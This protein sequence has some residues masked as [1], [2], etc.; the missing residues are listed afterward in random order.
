MASSLFVFLAS[1]AIHTSPT[2]DTLTGQ[3]SALETQFVTLGSIDLIS[4]H[5]GSEV[6]SYLSQ[7]RDYEVAKLRDISGKIREAALAELGSNPATEAEMQLFKVDEA[8]LSLLHILDE[9]ESLR[10]SPSGNQNYAKAWHGLIVRRNSAFRSFVKQSLVLFRMRRFGEGLSL[11]KARV[12]LLTHA[13]HG[14]WA[15]Q[16]VPYLR[17]V[18]HF[19]LHFFSKVES[20]YSPHFTPK[21]HRVLDSYGSRWNMQI[22]AI[23]FD[24][25]SR[26]RFHE[27]GLHVWVMNH[28]DIYLDPFF[29]SQIL[30][31]AS[32]SWDCHY[33]VDPFRYFGGQANR[34]SKRMT[35][36]PDFLAVGDQSG[37]AIRQAKEIAAASERANIFIFPEATTSLFGDTA[38]LDPYFA[39]S[40]VRSLKRLKIPGGLHFHIVSTNID[41][42]PRVTFR[43]RLSQYFRRH[44]TSPVSIQYHGSISADEI[45]NRMGIDQAFEM[46]TRIWLAFQKA[47]ASNASRLN[48]QLRSSSLQSDILNM[49]QRELRCSD[50]LPRLAPAAS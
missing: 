47:Q 16:L 28:R 15:L 20:P 11:A 19:F 27:K 32:C 29:V 33:A 34:I 38:L 31:S 45:P 50:I 7:L 6:E 25:N 22:Q 18:S 5:I 1:I 8:Y 4:G 40:F 30:K 35:E 13:E 12:S 39:L 24:E 10:V 3:E 21:M 41:V 17:S 37:A 43:Q 44:H 49:V 2:S 42:S 23:G 26:Q 36:M 46:N 9:I 48:G 14:R